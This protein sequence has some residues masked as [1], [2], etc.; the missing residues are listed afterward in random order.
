MSFWHGQLGLRVCVCVCTVNTCACVDA[1]KYIHVLSEYLCVM[2]YACVVYERM[3]VKVMPI[4][5]Y[6]IIIFFK[7][8]MRMYTACVT[9]CNIQYTRLF[10]FLYIV[11]ERCLK[12]NE[13]KKEKARPAL[14]GV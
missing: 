10:F 11:K 9:R 6:I 7:Y 12:E 13:K 1:R 3:C 2:V 5:I 8:F 4:Y 14:L